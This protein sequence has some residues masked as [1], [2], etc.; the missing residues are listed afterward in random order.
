MVGV[1]LAIS[2]WGT[3]SD[4]ESMDC[5]SVQDAA[6]GVVNVDADAT[7]ESAMA[8]AGLRVMVVLVADSPRGGP[9][10]LPKL[11]ILLVSYY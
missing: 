11:S 5:E 9:N 1:G 2:E 4:R 6:V 8:P 10:L 3:G 7:A